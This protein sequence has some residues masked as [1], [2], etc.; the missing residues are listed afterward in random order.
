MIIIGTQSPN[1]LAFLTQTTG[2]IDKKFHSFFFFVHRGKEPIIKAS[3][4]TNATPAD[5]CG[6]E[7][8]YVRAQQ[9]QHHAPF[10]PD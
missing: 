5:V 9:Q 4:V 7:L 10:H 6:I 1:R 3:D 8:G 2:R